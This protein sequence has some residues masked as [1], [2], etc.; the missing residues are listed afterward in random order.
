MSKRASK[1]CMFVLIL[2]IGFPLL[3]IIQLFTKIQAK[4]TV[5]EIENR[6]VINYDYDE[7]EKE[8][9]ERDKELTISNVVKECTKE[10]PIS[11]DE[12]TTL[13]EVEITEDGFTFLYWV[14]YDIDINEVNFEELNRASYKRT[15]NKRVIALCKKEKMY[16][17]HKYMYRKKSQQHKC[18]IN[19][20]EL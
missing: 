6:S 16:I 15:N 11:I 12:H 14:D 19:P 2:I 7:Y 13:S 5:W 20:F 17:C 3:C 10:L 8:K 9:A 1:G 18:L 4:H